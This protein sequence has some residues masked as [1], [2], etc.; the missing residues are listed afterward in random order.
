MKYDFDSAPQ[1]K[2]TACVKYDGLTQHYGCDDLTP[3][4]VADMDFEVLPEITDALLDRFNHR[5]Y[6][7]PV[8]TDSYRQAVTD[9]ITDRYDH[10][11]TTDMVTYVP[12]IVRGFALAVNFF[13]APGDKILIQPPVYHPF[14]I[15]TE[16]NRRKIVENPLVRT[17]DGYTM[18]L[19]GLEKVVETERPRLM[20][21]CNPHNP[22]GIQWNADTLRSVAS[23][24]RR[25]NMTV[26]SDEIHGDLMLDNKKHISFSSVSD[27]A[28]EVAVTFGAP[29]KTFNIAGLV[30]SWVYIKNPEL[31]E[32]FFKW[33]EVNEFNAPTFVAMTA[34]E[35]AYRHGGQWLNQMN[36]YLT[37]NVNAVERFFKNE[38]PAIKPVRPDASFLIWLDCRELSL[39]HD[40]LISLFIDDA[41]LA[42]NDGA[43]F[44]SEGD[45]YMRLNIGEPRIAIMEALARLKDAVD[46]L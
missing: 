43:M 42:L 31:R 16:G 8:V 37:A 20:V 32:P 35:A 24:A 15:V 7:Y 41:K 39:S 13:T 26:I 36:D 34:T 2:Q 45:G 44:G 3:M 6:G 46:K 12:G 10:D 17:D 11:V 30:S 33:L 5:V 28:A 19:D 29:S 18:D 4:L 1:R 38:L 27:D 22:G 40:R 23:I 14:K 21:L 25:Y 9:W